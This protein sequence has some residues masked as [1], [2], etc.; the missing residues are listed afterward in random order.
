MIRAAAIL[1][2]AP[3][4]ILGGLAG[5]ASLQPTC[6]PGATAGETAQLFFGRNIAGAPGVSDADWRA[7]VDAEIT[8]RFPDGLTVL[9]A[10]G[11]WRGASGA[12]EREASKVVVLMLSGAPDEEGRLAAVRAAYK[13]RFQQEAVLQ[14]RQKACVAF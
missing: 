5:C 3:V 9:D 12:V 7:F 1:G 8:P 4:L 14:V 13:A 2:L 11:Q 6:A 10:A